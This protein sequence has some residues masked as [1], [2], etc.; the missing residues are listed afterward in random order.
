MSIRRWDPFAELANL[1]EQMNRMWDFLRPP[2]RE[3]TGPRVDV[4][5]TE[6]EVV[7]TAEVPGIESKDELEVSVA[8]D[9]ISIKGEIKRGRDVKDEDYYHSERFYGS[10]AR[11][12][13]L[14]VEVKPEQA[15]AKLQNGVLEV[16]IPKAEAAKPR[17]YRVPIE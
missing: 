5:L 12:I 1:R 16:R 17:T 8:P 11:T 15:K 14:P 6:D 13:P 9:S 10:F 3:V 2:W 7:A 4:Y